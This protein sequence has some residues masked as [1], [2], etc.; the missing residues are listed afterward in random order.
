MLSIKELEIKIN[1][2]KY[3]KET[4]SLL[5]GDKIRLKEDFVEI[6]KMCGKHQ[7]LIEGHYKSYLRLN[8]TYIV[9][10]ML[11]NIRNQSYTY[12]DIKIGESWFSEYTFL[13][14]IFE[15]VKD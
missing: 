1:L 14:A 11:R 12:L 15:K 5:E 6:L 13:A 7:N 4:N 2:E 8:T 10:R 3:E 9:H